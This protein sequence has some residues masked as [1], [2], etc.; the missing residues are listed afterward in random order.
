MTA[1]VEPRVDTVKLT[2]DGIEVIAPKGE[3]VIRIAEQHGHRD[4][5]LLR[6]P[7]A[8]TGRRLPPVP[9]RRRGPAQAG[10]FVHAAGRRRHGRQDPP[11]L[12]GSREGPGRRH[13]TAADEPPAR[14][15]DV[16]QGRRVPAAEPGDVDRPHGQPLP[17]AEAHLRE[18]DRISSQVLL[19]RE[20]CV[21]CQRCTRF[22]EEIAG[23]NF[24]DLME[25]SSAE[26]IGV[27]R[28]AAFENPQRPRHDRR[29]RRTPRVH[30]RDWRRRVQ[31][32]L[33]RQ[34]HPDLPGRRAD[35]RAVPLPRPPVR[36]GLH[37][38]APA[39][40]AP[41]AARSAPTTAAAR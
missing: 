32:V 25:R 30:G 9:R 23:D 13:G 33:L 11:D 12:A 38:R 28:D 26:Q 29:D 3:L 36:P 5:P 39:S 37:A 17:R 10:R 7:A 22:S 27:Y 31:L 41:P 8:R 34:H 40:T 19:D 18:A 6:S 16:R 4:P 20:R 24:I 35:Q 21:L 15:P 2:I 14:L 1:E